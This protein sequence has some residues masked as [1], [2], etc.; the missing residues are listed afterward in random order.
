MHRFKKFTALLLCGLFSLSLMSCT[1]K[2]AA[3]ESSDITNVFEATTTVETS[4]STTV[5]SETETTVTSEST[6]EATT[7]TTETSESTTAATT[8]EATTTATTETSPTDTSASTTS[9]E[10]SATSTYSNEVSAIYTKN[11]EEKKNYIIYNEAF[12]G[13]ITETGLNKG[14]IGITIP[15][16]G[17]NLYGN[18]PAEALEFTLFYDERQNLTLR[19]LQG[20]FLAATSTGDLIL[21][22]KPVEDNYQFWRLEKADGGWHIINVG[23]AGNQALQYSSGTFSIKTC[24]NTKEFVFNF[25]E[26]G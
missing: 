11:P 8:T 13:T 14:F 23:A 17:T 21:T 16:D 19:D 4:E 5:T 15:S 2:P 10:T 9:S 1:T 7:T 24:A 18:I 6:T 20:R 3:T 25:Y 12:G 26:V 22:D